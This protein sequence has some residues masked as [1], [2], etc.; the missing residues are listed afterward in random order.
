[1][2]WMSFDHTD[3]KITSFNW[4]AP[5]N[6][7]VGSDVM[8][9]RSEDKTWANVAA[10]TAPLLRLPTEIRHKIYEYLFPHPNISAV[11]S[12][13]KVVC[14]FS[15]AGGEEVHTDAIN[16][17]CRQLYQETAG[18][19]LTQ[20]NVTMVRATLAQLIRGPDEIFLG[21]MREVT[22]ITGFQRLMSKKDFDARLCPVLDLT[23]TFTQLRIKIKF[24]D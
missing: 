13:K 14:K 3:G 24:D 23:K 6:P 2:T 20:A 1:M 11:L 7:Y 18:F 9:T 4:D 10:P 16:S 5:D 17:V 21:R 15:G 22:L 12:K 19:W 8:F